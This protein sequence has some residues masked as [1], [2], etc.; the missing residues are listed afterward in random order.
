V[1]S[2][3]RDAIGKLAAMAA[4][5]ED[6]ER[7][8]ARDVASQ[9]LARVLDEVV[10]ERQ[11]ERREEQKETAVV[12]GLIGSETGVDAL[13]RL[14]REG[15]QPAELR[16]AALEA[17][18]LAAKR[19]GGERS[20]LRE[21][22]E[23]L[24]EEQLRADALD[25]LVVGEEGWAEHDRRLPLLQGASRG[26]QLAASADLPLLGSGVI[27]RVPMLTLTAIKEGKG[28]RIRTEV[29]NPAV[30][31]LPLPQCPGMYPQQLDLIVVPGGEYKIGSPKKEDGRD[32]YTQI[33][34]KC[35]GVNVEAERTISLKPFALVRHPIT[36]AQWH[37]VAD[38]PMLEHEINPI[39]SNFKPDN[40]WERYA[41]PGGL[42]V[43]S[44]SWFYCQ[45]WLKRLNL[46]LEGKWLELGGL[47]ACCLKAKGPNPPLLIQDGNVV[48]VICS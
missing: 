15:D 42:P 27:R 46:W 34:Q 41:Q 19:L 2:E 13:G 33:R 37:A 4:A 32:V 5:L 38:L 47:G 1:A 40:L 14:A 25:L 22:M 8:A 3:R 11:A 39:P 7:R 23:G 24:L 45:E 16:R 29:V 44:V 21:R 9:R 26:L 10:P 17:L 35:E 31:K 28:L 20:P 48:S 18:G 6:S 30:W 36:H 12:L 43:D